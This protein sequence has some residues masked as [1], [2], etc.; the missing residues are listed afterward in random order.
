[1]D[2]ENSF[3]R[4]NEEARRALQYAHEEAHRLGHNSIG[5]AHLLLGLVR[6]PQCVAARALQVMQLDLATIRRLAR[7]VASHVWSIGEEV[8]LTP[9][10]K[11]VIER[12]VFEAN[13]AGNQ[14][15]GSEHLLSSDVF[16][17]PAAR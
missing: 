8:R 13:Q 12:A 3:E 1:M 11:R 9:G 4:F 6:D 14:E 10:G 15:I 7:P 2:N 16:P 17:A 5:T